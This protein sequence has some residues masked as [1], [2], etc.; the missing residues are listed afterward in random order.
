LPVLYV[1]GAG[2]N[3][4]PLKA[5]PGSSLIGEPSSPDQVLAAVSA[6]LNAVQ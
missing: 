6:L 4:W 2:A 1:T 3:D 5:V